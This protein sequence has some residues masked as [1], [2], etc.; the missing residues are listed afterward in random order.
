MGETMRADAGS[1]VS[2]QHRRRPRRGRQERRNERG[3]RLLKGKTSV[4]A[5]RPSRSLPYP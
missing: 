3:G 4:R 5:E 2:E 1:F